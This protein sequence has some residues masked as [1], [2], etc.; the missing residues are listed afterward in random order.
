MNKTH[1]YI[2]FLLFSLSMLI[3]T[4]ST[5]DRSYGPVKNNDYLSKIV[6]K[7]YP[8]SAL[9]RDQLMIGILRAN[10]DSFRG[11]N[12]HFLKV[13]EILTLPDEDVVSLIDKDEAKKT[14]KEHLVFFKRGRPGKFPAIPLPTIKASESTD[15]A[16]NEKVNIDEEN[17]KEGV[18]SNAK[19]YSAQENKKSDESQ[20][21]PVQESVANAAKETVE[22]RTKLQSLESEKTQQDEVL[23]SLEMQIQK[24]E[25]ELEST[26]S[27]E[28]QAEENITSSE[29]ESDSSS[30][31]SDNDALEES[32]IN[33]LENNLSSQ[34]ES[35]VV[36]VQEV[37]EVSKTE[38][39]GSASK[40]T[41][42]E[43]KKEGEKVVSKEIAETPETKSSF[44]D[45][46]IPWWVWIIPLFLLPLLILALVFKSKNRVSSTDLPQIKE[47]KKKAA[48][49]DVLHVDASEPVIKTSSTV[50]ESDDAHK[51]PAPQIVAKATVEPGSK[52]EQEVSLKIDMAR[53]YLDMD[54]HDAAIEILNEIDAEG[55]AVQV[56]RAKEIRARI[57]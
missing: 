28:K 34:K 55:N 18:S 19:S 16:V 21:E 17:T 4:I 2:V 3:S 57:L 40:D 56:E 38:T 33:A 43:E 44:M 32:T 11:G 24:L 35:E 5:A 36:V 23:Q 12:V 22:S 42:V 31:V 52:S 48:V 13:G 53:A 41:A 15:A 8:N 25:E 49:K 10:H 47:P 30:F 37:E 27:D 9:S 26:A 45:S 39:V 7:N 20:L 54:Y 50:I 6:N 1:S 29:E 51:K 46:N 14:V